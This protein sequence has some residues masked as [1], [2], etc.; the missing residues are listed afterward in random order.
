MTATMPRI[1]LYS[2]KI[3]NYLGAGDP[4]VELEF[5]GDSGLLCG[6][7]NSGKSTILKALAALKQIA[8]DLLSGSSFGVQAGWRAEPLATADV[9]H[10][11]TGSFE[12]GATFL[13]PHGLFGVSNALSALG[14]QAADSMQVRFEVALTAQRKS[15]L[16]IWFKDHKVF[17]PKG[18]TGAFRRQDG[19]LVAERR[20]S[21]VLS[22]ILDLPKLLAA[23]VWYFPSLRSIGTGNVSDLDRLAAGAG[24]PDWVRMARN[25]DAYKSEQRRAANLLQEFEAEF[26]TFAGFGKLE[27]MVRESGSEINAQIDDHLRPLSNLGS[28]IGETLL[29]LLCAKIAYS[30]SVARDLDVLL[31][32]EPELHLHPAL[33]RKLLEQLS[34]YGVQVIATTHSPTVVN[35][36]ARNQKRVFRTELVGELPSKAVRA[37]PAKGLAELREL[38]ES[39]GLSPADVLLADKVL[40]VE[41]TNDVPVFKAWLSKAP[42]YRGQNVAVL[43]LGGSDAAGANFDPNQWTSLHPRI[44]A[45]LDS[46]RKSAEEDPS[47]QRQQM[48]HRLGASGIHCHLTEWRSIESYFTPRAL[49]QVYGDCPADLDQFGAPNLIEQGVKQFSKSRNGEVAQAMEWGEIEATDIGR[50]MEDFLKS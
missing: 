34:Q 40:L 17:D 39:I 12:L 33:Q 46:E 47:A 18:N 1:K 28:G 29:I 41:G 24:I 43:S 14:M 35:W 50:E 45:I 21:D 13:V 20:L 3:R 6:P 15:L 2:I 36:F 42:S 49:K 10:W 23:R 30:G 9:F 38:I 19:W 32:E 11:G 16:G 5:N 8:H 48:K 7:N 44:R 27:L 26:A 37:R 22:P 25:P 31:L 4:P